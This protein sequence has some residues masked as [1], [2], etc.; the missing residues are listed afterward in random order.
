MPPKSRP[1]PEN[2]AYGGQA[3]AD[4][5]AAFGRGAAGGRRPDPGHPRSGSLAAGGSGGVDLRR[6]R[7]VAGPQPAGADPKEL[8]LCA[9]FR[10]PQTPCP[11]RARPRG[12]QNRFPPSGSE[13]S[14]TSFRQG[15]HWRF[16]GKMRPA[17]GRRTRSPAAG[18]GA[19]LVHP[20]PRI[21]APNGSTSLVRSAPTKERAP[22]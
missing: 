7:R 2:T 11:E 22:A 3:E 18:P 10:P 17:L 19:E 13:R 15:P 21:S 16:G 12:V 8:G 14:K 6:I 4:A 9:P 20:H 1:W 5:R